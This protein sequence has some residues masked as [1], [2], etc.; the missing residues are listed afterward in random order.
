M[1]GL[2]PA[3]QPGPP[4]SGGAGR[5]PV[6]RGW[7]R[8]PGRCLPGDNGFF[9]LAAQ[10]VASS[11]RAPEWER[12]RCGP[13]LPEVAFVPAASWQPRSQ[14]RQKGPRGAGMLPGAALSRHPERRS[15]P[16][17]GSEARAFP[18]AGTCSWLMGLWYS[19]SGSGISTSRRCSWEEGRVS[20]TFLIGP[21]K[22]QKPLLGFGSGLWAELSGR[23][24]LAMPEGIEA[25]GAR[26]LLRERRS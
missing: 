10:F 7:G 11:C 13:R 26:C 17:M 15:R 16:G 23:G 8:Q 2:I 18:R 1:L 22:K 14:A 24:A 20:Y 19:V 6:R 21:N 4:R 3:G 25:Y 12:C 9:C 5:C